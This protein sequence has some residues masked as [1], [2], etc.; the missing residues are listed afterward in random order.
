MGDTGFMTYTGSRKVV[1]IWR[2]KLK[3]LQQD[4]QV[5]YVQLLVCRD[6]KS[7]GLMMKVRI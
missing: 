1:N 4:I 7:D 5:R 3:I 6:G 2:G